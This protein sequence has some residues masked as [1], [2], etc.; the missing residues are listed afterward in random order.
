MFNPNIQYRCTIIRGKA[1]KELD[2]LLPTYANIIAAICPCSKTT[3]AQEFNN[4]LAQAIYKQNFANINNA[5]QKTIRNHITETAGKLFGLYI[6]DGEY[7]YESDSNKKLLLDGDQPAF[8]K[9]L[10]LNFQFPNATQK[11]QT[12]TERIKNK[13][14]FKPFHFILDLLVNANKQNIYLNKDEISYYVLNAKQV[15]QGKIKASEVLKVILQDRKNN[16]LKKL[17]SGSY[18]NQ[19]IKELL[20]LLVLSNLISI[21][22]N[23]LLINQTEEKVINI[24]IDE[25]NKPLRFD[26]YKYD[27]NNESHKKQMYYDWFSYFGQIAVIDPIFY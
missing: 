27:L 18:H 21:K 4:F 10:C 7:I 22:N 11:I 15:L 25:L 5:N 19:H 8:F 2:N 26:I 17:T 1:Q 24:F 14:N 23:V 20:N 6:D 16:N 9:N 3:F 12:I 13:I